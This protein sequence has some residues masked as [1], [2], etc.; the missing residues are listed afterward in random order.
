MKSLQRGWKRK[1]NSE[2]P[3][4]TKELMEKM[5]TQINSNGL[6]KIKNFTNGQFYIIAGMKGVGK[7]AFL[8]SA[9]YETAKEKIKCGFITLG[10]TE[11][12]I[13]VKLL[14]LVSDVPSSKLRWGMLNSKDRQK[15]QNGAE[16]ISNLPFE[17]VEMGKNDS[18]DI[19]SEIHRL[20]NEEKCEMVFVDSLNC[21]H[22]P[23]CDLADL[24]YIDME[25]ICD[26]FKRCAKELDIP[27]VAALSLSHI[28]KQI[29]PIMYVARKNC[30]VFMLLERDRY[31]EPE[32]NFIDCQLRI[33]KNSGFFYGGSLKFLPATGRFLFCK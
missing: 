31:S 12:D 32:N 4:N 16:E 27:I 1:L 18:C 17:I 10:K 15:L 23:C 9:F 3:M 11:M 8:L 5:L 24:K 21:V 20:K 19:C 13:T 26:G 6:E 2:N 33:W 25:F 28:K 30:D 7:S 14:S 22:R 29:V